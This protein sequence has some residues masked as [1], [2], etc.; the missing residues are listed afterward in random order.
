MAESK[1]LLL[2]SFHRDPRTMVD[3]LIAAES[4]CYAS[5]ELRLANEAW[6]RKEDVRFFPRPPD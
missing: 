4:T 6:S 3:D 2:K 5:W 1:R